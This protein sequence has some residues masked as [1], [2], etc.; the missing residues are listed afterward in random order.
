MIREVEMVCD[1]LSVFDI[2]KTT[3][4]SKLKTSVT[5][6]RLR[7][8]HKKKKGKKELISLKH[9]KCSVLLF[10]RLF[11]FS[12]WRGQEGMEHN[13]NYSLRTGGV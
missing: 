11:T 4:E 8:P 5:K 2:S 13:L 7:I 10:T 9:L 6:F 1:L 3:C 12:F